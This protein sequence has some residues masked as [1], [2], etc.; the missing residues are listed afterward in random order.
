MF[1]RENFRA[2]DDGRRCSCN[3]H[4]MPNT[5][6]ALLAQVPPVLLA[7]AL[8]LRGL[9]PGDVLDWQPPE[10][11][12][13]WERLKE[14]DSATLSSA[15]RLIADAI[16]GEDNRKDI[17]DLERAPEHAVHVRA[18]DCVAAVFRAEDIRYYGHKPETRLFTYNY[19]KDVN[20]CR[21]EPFLAQEAG[22]YATAFLVAPDL[23]V[24]A[25]HVWRQ[26]V[27]PRF[28]FGFRMVDRER[29]QVDIPLTEVYEADRVV[30]LAYDRST[31]ADWAVIRLSR[32]VENHEPARIRRG[33]PPP[34]GTP[35]YTIGHPGGLPLKFSDG[36]RARGW[37][38]RDFLIANLD[39]LSHSSGSPVFNAIDHVV[40]GLVVATRDHEFGPCPDG[41]EKCRALVRN[42]E[43]GGGG[44]RCT[45]VQQFE[46]L[47][48]N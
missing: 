4:D 32:K 35:L 31:G 3:N 6:K 28:V 23:V 25:G 34:A 19:G 36:A 11:D 40:E 21:H 22:A 47:I 45:L 8:Q 41:D 37:Y 44:V 33:D 7:R 27:H 14:V 5:L 12:G 46:G 20:L 39:V 1:A 43:G 29:A 10:G 42:S 13:D 18:A 24:T 30:D 16:Y 38:R 15:L 17:I 9:G 26:V 2:P 48:P